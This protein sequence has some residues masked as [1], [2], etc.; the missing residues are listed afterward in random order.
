MA[1]P[2]PICK[3]C[4]YWK[5]VQKEDGYVYCACVCVWWRVGGFPGGSMGKE[6]A[7]NVGDSGH[8]GSIPGPATNFS[9]F[10]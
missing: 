10:A 4:I 1:I 6:S 5:D 8:V 2:S 9:I 7:Y 3:S